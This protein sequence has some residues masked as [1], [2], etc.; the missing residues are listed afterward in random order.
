[1]PKKMIC[2]IPADEKER[3]CDEHKNCKTCPFYK[4]PFCYLIDNYGVDPK[5]KIEIKKKSDKHRGE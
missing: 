5:E 2:N 4:W 1:M 3:I